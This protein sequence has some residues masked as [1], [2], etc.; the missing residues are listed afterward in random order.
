[1]AYR[2][3]LADDSQTIH[4]VITYTLMKGPFQLDVSSTAEEMEQKLEEQDY[5]IVLLDFGL[6]ASLDGHELAKQVHQKASGAHIIMLLGSFDIV[7][8]DQLREVN[9]KEKLVKPF[10]GQELIK[11]CHSVVEASQEEADKGDQNWQMNAPP[12]PPPSQEGAF[13]RELQDWSMDVPPIIGGEQPSDMVTAENIPPIIP[14]AQSEEEEV[15][16]TPTDDPNRTE[17][18]EHNKSPQMKIPDKEDLEFPEELPKDFGDSASDDDEGPESTLGDT[19]GGLHLTPLSELKLDK[20]SEGGGEESHDPDDSLSLSETKSIVIEESIKEEVDPKNFWTLDS[21]EDDEG[22]E[23][24]KEAKEE[25]PPAIKS[26][27]G[28]DIDS[29]VERLMPLVEERIR[30]YCQQNVEKVAWEVIPE[31]AENI[32]KK[33]LKKL[34]IQ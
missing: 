24:T 22:D 9:V 12:C 30:Q 8:E 27:D 11:I 23:G 13:E 6:S 25:R 28:I 33:R 19:I 31:L 4:K 20:E 29:I 17:M 16:E 26:A 21:G 34:K 1:M 3:L 18:Y 7:D 14:Q 2:V 15:A 10:D 5:D 32:I